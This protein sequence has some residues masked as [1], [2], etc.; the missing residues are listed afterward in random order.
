MTHGCFC[1]TVGPRG[2]AESCELCKTRLASPSIASFQI[3]CAILH[4]PA[5]LK[6]FSLVV[7]GV[8]CW[9]PV[10]ALGRR[11]ELWLRPPQKGMVVQREPRGCVRVGNTVM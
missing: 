6:S 10:P 3:Q 8:P 9:S 1:W 4:P 7:G 2:V 11:K 5:V